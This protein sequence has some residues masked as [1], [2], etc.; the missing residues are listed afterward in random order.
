MLIA[1][2]R[3]PNRILLD[4]HHLPGDLENQIS[5]FVDRLLQP[6]LPRDYRQRNFCGRIRFK[7]TPPVIGKTK[8]VFITN[9]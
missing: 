4:R 3:L 2:I 7:D 6:T 5:A 9:N 1:S 8:K